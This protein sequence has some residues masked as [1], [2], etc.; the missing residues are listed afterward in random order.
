MG[1]EETEA[2]VGV[3]AESLLELRLGLLGIEKLL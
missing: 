1:V 3:E 2:S